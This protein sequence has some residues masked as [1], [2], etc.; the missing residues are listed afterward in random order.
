MHK[1]TKTLFITGMLVYSTVSSA[2]SLVQKSSPPADLGVVNKE[3][4]LYWLEKRGELSA[5]AST[6]EKQLAFKNYIANASSSTKTKYSDHLALSLKQ[7]N[8]TS[9]LK[10]SVQLSKINA[11]NLASEDID[12]TVKVLAIMIDFQDLKYSEHGLQSRDTD[13]YYADYPRSHYENLLFSTDGYSGPSGQ[14]IESAYQYYQHESGETLSFTG[15]AF[16][17]IT[18]DNNAEFYGANSNDENDSNVQE[19]VIEAVTKAIAENQINLS[20]YDKTDYFD[21]DNDNNINEPD[22]IVDHIMIFHAS[23]GEEAGG[24]NLGSNAI[25]SHRFFVFDDNQQPISVTGSTTKIYGYTINPI[26]SATGV[27]V[28]EFGHDL[29]ADDEYDTVNTDIGSPV[30]SWSVMASGSWLGTPSGTQPSSFSPSVREYFQSKY[31]GNWVNQ[32]TITLSDTL[33]ETLTINAA[34][35]HTSGINQI[36]VNLPNTTVDFGQPFSGSYQ[37]YSNKGHLLRNKLTFDTTVTGSNATL[38]M[39][40]RWDIEQDYDYILVKANNQVIAGNHTTLTNQYYDSINNFIT[41]QSANITGATTPLGW[42]DLTFSLSDFANQNVTIEIEYITDESAGGYGF[43]ADDIKITS[44]ATTA[45]SN[46]AETLFPVILNGFSRIMD[47]SSVTNHH[48][49]VQLRNNTVTDSALSTIDYDPGILIWY[50]NDDVDDNNTSQHPGEVSIG[51]VDAD[52]TLIKRN[53][54]TRTTEY[55]L[56][57]AAFSLYNQSASSNDTSLTN[58]AL[59]ND[60][61]DYS[62]PLQPESG[63]NLPILGLNI[64]VLTQASDSSTA[65]ILLSKNDIHDLVKTQNGLNVNIS[66]EDSDVTNSSSFIWTMGDGTELTSNSVNHTYQNAGTYNVEVSYTTENGSKQLY[67]TVVVGEPIEGDINLSAINTELSFNA[68]LMGGL[69]D[70]IYRWKMGDDEGV[71]TTSSGSYTYKNPGVFTVE[72]TITDETGESFIFD[73]SISINTPLVTSFSSTNTN[74]V[75][76]FISDVSGGSQPYAYSW[77][78]G[79]SQTSTSSSPSHTYSAAGTYTV[80]LI[81]T[82][83]DNITINTSN[84]ITVSAATSSVANNNTNSSN[85]S[86]SSGGS[87]HWMALMFMGLLVSKKR[88]KNRSK[89]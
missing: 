64:E 34:T 57:D 85:T 18:A 86:G 14:N 77:D 55:Q 23:V 5:N 84:N 63:I 43:A 72:L 66:I 67:Q 50:G 28:H 45:F 25:W 30:Q 73:K 6:E 32:Q 9:A 83:A 27:V 35:D 11:P 79:D 20:D 33:N 22:G 46:G 47:T 48:Y 38:S 59:F 3:R 68:T 40:A 26:D 53:N 80:N 29:G 10:S 19:L 75:A 17:W 7:N 2:V 21:R 76:N 1:L 4:I 15:N 89:A 37:Y 62:S 42:A 13:M 51:V 44:G 49:Y 82:D 70:F 74:L 54:Q 8:Q 56:R 52:Q 36:K 88:I 39:K 81:I 58:N 60:K 61:N 69:G 87:F 71:S 65:T 16:G 12:N 31:D 24:G 78:F 41:G